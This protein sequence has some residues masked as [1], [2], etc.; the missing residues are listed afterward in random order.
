MASPQ[1]LTVALR[2][3][4]ENSNEL[5]SVIVAAALPDF[6]S[7]KALTA[8]TPRTR[9]SLLS[10]EAQA[11]DRGASTGSEIVES[12]SFTTPHGSIVQETVDLSELARLTVAI[13]EPPGIALIGTTDIVATGA[14]GCWW[15]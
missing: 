14:G 2:W 1:V 4:A 15:P 7:Q 5:R 11:L 8:I 13:P 3:R 10:D 12:I 6:A 9:H